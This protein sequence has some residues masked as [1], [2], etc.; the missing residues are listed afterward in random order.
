MA[1]TLFVRVQDDMGND[2]DPED[3]RT[4]LDKALDEIQTLTDEYDVSM[5]VCALQLVCVNVYVGINLSIFFPMLCFLSAFLF[6]LHFFFFL[7]KI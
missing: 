4:E 2:E 7:I 1:R 5:C 6:F 3:H